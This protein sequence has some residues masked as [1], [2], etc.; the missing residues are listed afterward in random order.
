MNAIRIFTFWNKQ[1]IW[2]RKHIK[3]KFMAYSVML[4]AVV[5][6]CDSDPYGTQ[7]FDEE[8]LTIYQYL[9]ANQ[10]EYSKFC[11]LLEKGKLLGTLGAYNPYE[12][13]YTLFV[14]TDEAIDKFIEQNGKYENFDELLQDTSFIYTLTRYHTLNKKLHTDK[15]PDGALYDRTL[16]GNRL[17][18]GVYTNTE[19]DI[20]LIKINNSAPVIKSNIDLTNGYIHVISEVLQKVEISGYDWLQ[21]HDEYTILAQAM[22]Y[23]RIRQKMWMDKYTILAEHDSIYSRNGILNL[24]DLLNRIAPGAS[25][26]GKTNALFKFSAYHIMSGELYLNDLNWGSKGYW[27]MD[28]KPVTINVG[29]DIKINPGVVNYGNEISESGDTI[30]IDYIS[31]VWEDS[32]ILTGTGPVHSISNLLLSEPLP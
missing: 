2:I 26:S 30:V 18:T 10:T 11:K 1:L 24:E 8:A 7:W 27:T 22:E 15:F 19:G 25:T 31:P 28:N 9:Q 21:Q 13:G 6:S 23:C 4:A 29:L 32:N 20:A 14:P 17:V 12:D 16:T 3:I 5:S